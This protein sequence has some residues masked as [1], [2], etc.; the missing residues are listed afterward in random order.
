MFRLRKPFKIPVILA[1]LACCSCSKDLGY[2]EVRNLTN[3]SL[4]NVTWGEHIH[5]GDIAPGEEK[6]EE[7][8]SFTS[9]YLYLK[10]GNGTY[11]S[12]EEIFVDANS[13]A[14]YIVHDK[15]QLEKLE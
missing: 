3:D 4:S 13:S 9:N 15:K 2:L 8:E 11:R 12:T 10:I 7:T 14:T 5:L 1:V 6:G